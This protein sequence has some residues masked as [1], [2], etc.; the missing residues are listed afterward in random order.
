MSTYAHALESHAALDTARF[1]SDV[2]FALRLLAR[3]RHGRLDVTFPDGQC[4]HFGDLRSSER[5]DLKLANWN[6]VRAAMK[7]G[8]IGFAESYIAGDWATSDLVR[9][10]EFF[11]ANRDGAESMIYG[12]FLGRI[13]YRVRHWL[14]RNTKTQ[15]RKNI[16]AHYDLGNDFY[17]LW[18]DRSMTY[19]SAL[20]ERR[21]GPHEVASP[22]ELEAA[23][24]AKYA[25]VLEQLD[26]APGARLLEIGC[27]WGGLAEAAA[28]AGLEVTGLTLST[29][30][31]TYARERLARAG[32]AADLRLR[33]YRDEAGRY[34]GIAS[35]EMF[36]AVGEAYWPSYF[37]TLK[38]C[39]KPGGRACLQTIVIADD[40][41]ERYR[42]GTDF[43]QQ[44]IFPGGMLPSPAAF[45]AQAEAAGLQIV[46]EH[47]FGADYARTLATWRARFHAR[48]AEVRALG[49]DKR[50]VRIWDFYLAYC[51]A[52]FARENTDVVQ[53]TLATR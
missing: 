22:E 49:F 40:L 20:F 52:A 53:Y 17:A 27:G 29:E 19:S 26:L 36:E 10:L 13:V 38:R 30:Q 50:F 8:D 16:H 45:R 35:I 24:R 2:R 31:L 43:I 21:A 7:S 33:D 14:N 41:F 47:R 37:A 5:A 39:L 25:R 1:P 3:M 23:Q 34:D 18:L 9:L 44:Y 46:E 4:A 6:M 11:V 48:L 15:A 32:L 42:S 28:R 12:S 51:E